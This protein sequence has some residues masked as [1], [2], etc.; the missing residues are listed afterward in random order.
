MQWNIYPFAVWGITG[1]CLGRGAEMMW[2]EWSPWT[3]WAIG[4][5]VPVI[6]FGAP[7]AFR[8]WLAPR[9]PSGVIK[10]LAYFW[11][12][13]LPRDLIPFV[14]AA[15]MVWPDIR[16]VIEGMLRGENIEGTALTKH[17][18]DEMFDGTKNAVHLYAIRP[19]S[20]RLEIIENSLNYELNRDLV[21]SSNPF[22]KDRNIITNIR[23]SRRD[24][25]RWLKGYLRGTDDG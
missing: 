7:A 2:P 23:V 16:N 1:F 18:W 10:R 9:F 25:R 4:A 14:E 15:D 19:P 13:G 11:G 20:A 12:D 5:V 17:L 22:L 3:W 6:G 8:R 21:T 24:V